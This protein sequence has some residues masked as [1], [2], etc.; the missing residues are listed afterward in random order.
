MTKIFDFDIAQRIMDNREE[1]WFY[2]GELGW[3]VAI[4]AEKS[5]FG[6]KVN[7]YNATSLLSLFFDYLPYLSTIDKQYWQSVV[8]AGDQQA[9]FEVFMRWREFRLPIEEERQRAQDRTK[10]QLAKLMKQVPRFTIRDRHRIQIQIR[11]LPYRGVRTPEENSA[12]RSRRRAR[13]WNCH[14]FLDNYEHFEC[15][16]CGW[17]LCGCG[18]CGC[19]QVQSFHR[20]PKCGSNFRVLDCRGSYP[21]CSPAC[22]YLALSVYSEYLK[23]PEWQQ[24][25]KLCLERDNQSCQDCG[26]PANEVHHLTYERIG[27]ERLE[28]LLSL[29]TP[30]HALRHGDA[31]PIANGE[32]LLQL[33]VP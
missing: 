22:R 10:E 7:V 17:I 18:A 27:N 32:A 14:K 21:F 24:R 4:L 23:S 28:D 29:C 25:R 15:R 16:S 5:D 9:F 30:C 13:C 2:L 19:G 20:C 6:S 11:G 3:H 33:F 31:G 26:L 8:R 12:L 1:R